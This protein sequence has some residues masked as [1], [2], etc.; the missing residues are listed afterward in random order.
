[1]G[2]VPAPLREEAGFVNT[3]LLG[4]ELA[5]GAA[6][7]AAW[8]ETRFG[9]RRPSSLRHRFAHTAAA[10][11]LL[12]LSA[13]ALGQLV[14]EGTPRTTSTALLFVLFLP[15]L[16]YAFVAGLWLLRTLTEVMR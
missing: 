8:V 10:F 11:V 7:L 3:S 13:L 6:L 2:V 12:Q 14:H 16:V 5:V 4:I 1:M 15:A 9:D